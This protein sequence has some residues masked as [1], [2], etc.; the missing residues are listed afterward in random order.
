MV[1]ALASRGHRVTPQRLAILE[2]LAKSEGHPTANQIL[3]RVQRR[4]P[5]AG[6][7]TVYNTI[8]LLKD[9]G[10]RVADEVGYELLS[11]RFDVY[12]LCPSCREEL[13]RDGDEVKGGAVVR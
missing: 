13:H 3:R 11:H 2:V 5:M 7:A 10:H 9:L 12:G 6:K 4:F 1:E 8:R